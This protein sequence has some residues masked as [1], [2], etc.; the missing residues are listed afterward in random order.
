MAGSYRVTV[1]ALEPDAKVEALIDV[2]G[3][4][5][6]LSQNCPT[7]EEWVQYQKALTDGIFAMA[8]QAVELKKGKK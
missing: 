4:H 3:V 1:I 6:V 5:T 7:Y 2:P 8:A